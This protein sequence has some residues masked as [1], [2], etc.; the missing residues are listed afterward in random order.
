MTGTVRYTYSKDIMG[1]RI[2]GQCQPCI[3]THKQYQWKW[4]PHRDSN[5]LE[6][7]WYQ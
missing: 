5:E 7:G 4:R 1:M 3:R 6:S 2:R